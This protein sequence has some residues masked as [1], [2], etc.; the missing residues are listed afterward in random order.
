[1]AGADTPFK[2]KLSAKGQVALPK[3][4]R[5]RLNWK[6]GEALVVE[7]TPDGVLLKRASPFASTRLEDVA[8]CL[9]RGGRALTIEEMDEAVAAEIRR[10]HARGRY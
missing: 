3:E 1:M 10:R 9:G 4:I 5:Q 6:S 7:E 8:G 2:T